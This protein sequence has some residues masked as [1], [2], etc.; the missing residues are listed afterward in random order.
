MTHILSLAPVSYRFKSVICFLH[1][2]APSNALL[3]LSLSK[4]F[5]HPTIIIPCVAISLCAFLFFSFL[6]FFSSCVLL[7]LRCSQSEIPLVV[8]ITEGIPQKDMA[9]VKHALRQQSATRLIG[10]NCP[11]IIK[12]GECKIGE[13][14][15]Q[16][17]SVAWRKGGSRNDQEALFSPQDCPTLPRSFLV[18]SSG[19]QN[20]KGS[21]HTTPNY[22][23]DTDVLPSV[24]SYSKIVPYPVFISRSRLP[25]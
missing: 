15:F 23:S 13:Y 4:C 20:R 6:V 11:G 1:R 9:R 18:Y 24:V 19:I 2:H 21:L 5:I 10:P 22:S 3:L 16:F 7:R 12:P 17:N 25:T 14:Q 8:C